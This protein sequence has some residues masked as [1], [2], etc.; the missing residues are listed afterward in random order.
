VATITV[1]ELVAGG[2]VRC[3]VSV[4]GGKDSTATALALREA[5]V[6]YR[7]VFAD[8]GWEAP[9]TYDHIK[10]LR[11]KL[12]PIDVVG[13]TLRVDAI[14]PDAVK[15]PDK[16]RTPGMEKKI[17][18]RAGFPARMQ[19]WCT[20]ELKLQVLKQYHEVVEAAEGDETCC[21]VGVRAS[22]SESRAKM[23][24]WED[25]DTW[26]GWM[27]RPILAWSIS[28]VL[29]IHHRHGVE[30]NPLYKRGHNRVGCFPCIYAGKDL[31]TRP[32]ASTG[33]ESSRKRSRSS[34]RAATR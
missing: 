8:T 11:Q 31:T 13:A 28:D 9:Q 14:P 23:S 24:A 15:D 33:S 12:G 25:D 1:P 4:S 18:A 32:I 3:I 17:L 27:W 6:P 26:G 21:V 2:H 5:G 22:E 7:M 16:L 10:H 30:V 20:R 19:R 34:A 29:E